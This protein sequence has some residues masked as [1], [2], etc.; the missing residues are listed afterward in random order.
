MEKQNIKEAIGAPRKL[1]T[2]LR[3]ETESSYWELCSRVPVPVEERLLLS[4]PLYY[5]PAGHTLIHSTPSPGAKWTCQGF[6][7][8]FCK[9]LACGLQKAGGVSRFLPFQDN[10]SVVSVIALCCCILSKVDFCRENSAVPQKKKWPQENFHI[11][12]FAQRPESYSKLLRGIAYTRGLGSYPR[13]RKVYEHN[14][15]PNL[16]RKTLLLLPVSVSQG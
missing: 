10:N 14:R 9:I 7:V 16:K 6:L 2:S 8:A 15:K 5:K 12:D 4:S 3:N 1:R 13:N 11:Q